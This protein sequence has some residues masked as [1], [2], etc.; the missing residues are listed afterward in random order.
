MNRNVFGMSGLSLN[1]VFCGDYE[2]GLFLRGFKGMIPTGELYLL[3]SL[4]VLSFGMLV[5][6]ITERNRFKTHQSL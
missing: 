2:W 4:Q 5:F 3:D 6:A 1:L